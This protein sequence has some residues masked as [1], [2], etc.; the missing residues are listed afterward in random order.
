MSQIPLDNTL[1]KKDTNYST[2]MGPPASDG[3]DKME[4]ENGDGSKEN[5]DPLMQDLQVKLVIWSAGDMS[6]V[7]PQWK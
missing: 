2:S 6:L 3:A 4:T 5:M 7:I 1:F